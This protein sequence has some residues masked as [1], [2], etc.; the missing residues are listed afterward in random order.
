[1]LDTDA[2]L[3]LNSK[4][5][6]HFSSVYGTLGS[7]WRPN[8]VLLEHFSIGIGALKRA[9]AEP[10]SCLVYANATASIAVSDIMPLMSLFSIREGVRPI[11][12]KL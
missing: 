4:V 11:I 12:K 5:V 3:C 7:F 2:F 1:M 10:P 6:L 9:Q 8:C